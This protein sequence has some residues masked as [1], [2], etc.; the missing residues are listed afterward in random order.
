MGAALETAIQA[1][2]DAEQRHAELLRQ[3]EEDAQA[4]LAL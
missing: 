2:A 1:K 4:E 3:V